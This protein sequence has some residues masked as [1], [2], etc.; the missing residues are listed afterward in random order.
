VGCHPRV[1]GSLTFATL[2][3]GNVALILVNRSWRLSI[4]RS[5]KERVNHVLFWILGVAA[6]QSVPRGKAAGPDR[7]VR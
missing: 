6:V 1:D 4:W 2:G 7:L 5:F 3:I